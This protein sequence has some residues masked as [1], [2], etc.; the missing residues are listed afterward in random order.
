MKPLVTVAIPAHNAAHWLGP[1]IE[2]AL[3]QTHGAVEVIVV[4][5]A[6]TDNTANVA[7]AF[8]ERIRLLESE[9]RGA[10]HAR[11]LAWQAAQGEWLQ[12]LDADDYLEPEKIAQQL[13][14]SGEGAQAEVIYSPVWWETWR[15]GD[16][17]ERV[18]STIDIRRDLFTQWLAWE[19]PQTG[20]GLWR[21]T[22][23]AG[24]GGWKEDQPCCQDNELYLRALQTGLRFVFA[25][26]AH[27]VYRIW[28]EETLCRKNP[29]QVIEVR[30]AL[31][32]ELRA[33][34]KESEL[35]T[36]G[37]QQAAAQACFE[38]ARSWAKDDLAGA[39]S[40]H[41]ARKALGLMRPAGAAAPAR[42]RF[43]YDL[44]G[45]AMAERVAGLLR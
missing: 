31:M 34:M 24:L 6:S 32:D 19:L 21:K 38:M 42:Y 2:S 1:A 44:L 11:N 23:L 45:F 25:P 26:T 22:A 12:F 4:N 17:V 16:A 35:W 5:D 15:D 33:W 14:E 41:E 37:H 36:E 43:I 29:R 13:A 30:T 27:A 7:R 39:V 18:K 40:Y 8:G 9:R 3:A 10:P 20:G 28:S